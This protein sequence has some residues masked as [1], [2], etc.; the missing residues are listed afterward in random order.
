MFSSYV[1][2]GHNVPWPNGKVGHN[3]HE[4]S[5]GHDVPYE[6]EGSNGHN[7]LSFL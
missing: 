7:V 3:V 1:N 4:E 6:W 5:N 2:S